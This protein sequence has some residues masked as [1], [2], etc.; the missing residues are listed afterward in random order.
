MYYLWLTLYQL[1]INPVTLAPFIP[2]LLFKRKTRKILLGQFG[3]I[4]RI[5]RRF[6]GE[7]RRVVWFHVASAGEYLQAKPVIDLCRKKG[8]EVFITATSVSGI[9]WLKRE[10]IEAEY[11]PWDFWFNAKKVVHIINPERFVYV[12][13]DIWPNLTRYLHHNKTPVTLI[14]GRMKRKKGG[15]FKHSFYRFLFTFIESL[16]ALTEEDEKNF[17]NLF[18]E[19]NVVFGGDS[20][21]DNVIERTTLT[22][23]DNDLDRI[24]ADCNKNKT[25][26]LGSVW[27]S[28]LSVIAP[29]LSRALK[30]NPELKV[31]LAPH[32]TTESG[33]IKS[34]STLPD[35]REFNVT[36]LTTLRSLPKKEAKQWQVLVVDTIGEL[37]YI[38]RFAS[39]AFIGGGFQKG[40]H[41]ILEPAVWGLQLSFGPDIDE[42]PETSLFIGNNGAFVVRSENDFSVVLDQ[43]LTANDTIKKQGLKNKELITTQSGSAK[44]YL[45]LIFP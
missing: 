33:I 37:F 13:T 9:E 30:N 45:K 28:D 8:K 2:L 34:L 20:R 7:Q 14:C 42:F 24:L 4:Q 11:L 41:N 10:K 39:L 19:K 15:L 5:S 18:P 38:Y 26:I 25:I 12:R 36:R 32:E 21:F 6:A 40:L 3:V 35:I 27:P 22:P 43:W 16:G 1:L 29:P 17:K 23:P 31:I 44:R